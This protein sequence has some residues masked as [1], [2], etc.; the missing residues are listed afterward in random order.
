MGEQLTPN[1][2]LEPMRGASLRLR[3]LIARIP[4]SARR[5]GLEVIVRSQPIHGFDSF[6][7]LA[8]CSLLSADSS[9]SVASHECKNFAPRS[10]VSAVQNSS[11]VQFCE[12]GTSVSVRI[13]L[14]DFIRTFDKVRLPDTACP[15]ESRPGPQDRE[16]LCKRKTRGV[17][18]VFVSVSNGSDSV[19]IVGDRRMPQ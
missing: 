17:A 19:S 15:P 13:S 6:L 2:P 9:L 3:W 1:G 8:P 12:K 5:M 4:Q 14:I 10:R 11:A 16:R 18:R 7:A